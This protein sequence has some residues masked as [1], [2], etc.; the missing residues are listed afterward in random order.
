M[1][2]FDSIPVSKRPSSRFDLSYSNKLTFDFGQLIPLTWQETLPGDKFHISTSFLMRMAPLV[3]PV[4]HNCNVYVHF[5]AVPYRLIWDE[6]EDFITGGPDGKFTTVP[7]YFDPYSPKFQD[8]VNKP[9]TLLDYM[10]IPTLSTDQG[11]PS[12]DG[13]FC[14]SLPFRAYNLIYSDYYRNENL[15]AEVNFDK[16]SGEED[17]DTFR[18]L[19]AIRFRGWEKDYFTSALPWPQRGAAVSIPVGDEASI[20]YRPSAQFPT[21]SVLRRPTDGSSGLFAANVSMQASAGDLATYV[22]GAPSAERVSLDVDNSHTLYAD[23]QE[24][25]GV[26]VENLRR[27]IRLQEF[28][29]LDARGG[30]R[31]IEVIR[32]HYGV[33]SSDSRLQRP[34]FLGGGRVPIGF[35]EVLQTSQT[36]DSSPQGQQAGHGIAAGN[37]LRVSHYSEEHEIIMGI[38]SVV[39]RSGYFQGLPRK[40]SRQDRFMYY[41]PKFANLGE[42]EIKMRE[43]YMQPTPEEPEQSNNLLFGY[44]PRYSEY[45]YNSDEVHG[46]FRNSLDFYHLARK[47]SSRPALNSTFVHIQPEETNRI[48]AVQDSGVNKLW[49]VFGLSIRARRPMPY[50]GTPHL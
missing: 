33:T 8:L 11:T 12:G 18:E 20:R 19:C 28:L 41:W 45:K 29:E 10:G 50:Y 3:A 16:T 49:A 21:G 44:T 15:D 17:Y 42:Q 37:I 27:M 2:I 13:E 46:D 1:S 26:T 40:F 6:F 36:T 25:S 7:P 35:S 9:G 47:F 38:V 14:S 30:S 23:L 22:Q 24:A 48:F 39:P 34:L 31:Y 4:M 5:F 32:A 43:L